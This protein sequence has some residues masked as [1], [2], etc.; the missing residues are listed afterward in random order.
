MFKSNFLK[1]VLLVTVFSFVVSC[2]SDEDDATVTSTLKINTYSNLFAP[3]TGGQGQPVGGEFVKFNFSKNEI[4]TDDSWDI[5]FRG[6]TVI[7]NGGTEIGITDEPSRTGNGAVS[8]VSGTLDSVT[9]VPNASAFV[10]D[11]M[12]NYAIP[13]G[14]GNGW[15]NYNPI[16]HLITPISGKIFIIKTHD[17]KYAKLEIISYY[18]DAPLNPD[19]TLSRYYT[20]KYVYQPIG[21]NF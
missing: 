15:Y 18:K 19:I 17:N 1:S 21:A 10:Q 7:V 8:I 5:A 20:F 2:S 4:V 14:N 12:N 3:Q 6:T 9:T 11:G 13:T 16:N